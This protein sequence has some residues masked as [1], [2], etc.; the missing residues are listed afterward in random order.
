MQIF[1]PRPRKGRK[2]ELKEVEEE[3]EE[4]EILLSQLKD[5]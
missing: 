3:E 5:P 1:G 4:G 2:E